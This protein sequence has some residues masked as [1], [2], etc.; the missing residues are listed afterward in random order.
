MADYSFEQNSNVSALCTTYCE[1]KIALFLYTRSNIL[2]IDFVTQVQFSKKRSH[3]CTC[4]LMQQSSYKWLL[5]W[6][7]PS[8]SQLG[9]SMVLGCLVLCL[10]LCSQDSVVS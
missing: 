1:S 4:T 3:T 2:K 9:V 7:C 5:F 6:R 10:V 8:I